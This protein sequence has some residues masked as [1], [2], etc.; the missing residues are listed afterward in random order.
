[1]TM[2]VTVPTES[3]DITNTTRKTQ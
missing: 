3:H 1:M 2:K